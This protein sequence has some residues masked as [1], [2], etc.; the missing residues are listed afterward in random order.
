MMVGLV[1]FIVCGFFTL[2]DFYWRPENFRKYKIQPNTSEPPDYK[3]FKK[4]ISVVL[5]V[6]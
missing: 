2:M 6:L 3:K 4:V 5:I 1:T